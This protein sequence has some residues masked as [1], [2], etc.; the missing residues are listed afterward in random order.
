MDGYHSLVAYRRFP[1]GPELSRL[2]ASNPETA[3]D[4]Q[5]DLAPLVDYFP[6]THVNESTLRSSAAYTYSRQ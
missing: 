6:V 4:M 5:Y 1:E 3:N 2:D